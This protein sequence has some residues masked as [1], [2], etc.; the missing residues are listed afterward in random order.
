[1][2][3]L[4]VTPDSFSDGNRYASP[5]VAIEH[6]RRM[7]E[8]GATIIDVGGES[9]RPGAEPVDAEEE[10]RRVLPVIEG[11]QAGMDASDAHQAGL[12]S[13]DTCKASVAEAALGAGAHI[14][15][16]VS[17]LTG[18]DRMAEV[19]RAAGAGLVLMHMRGE[20]RTM[21]DDPRYDDVVREVKSY[22]DTRVHAAQSAG[23]ASECLAIDPGIG[24]GKTVEHNLQLLQGLGTFIAIGLPV[25]VGLSRKRFLGKITGRETDG[26][27]AAGVAANVYS[28][29]HGAAV[30][31][32]HD[33]AETMD[34]MEMTAA[35]CAEIS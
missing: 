19:V 4:N 11:L 17:A 34:A 32:V 6:G 1:M 15:N 16:D 10:S 14:V 33:V 8:E 3:V 13:I 21:Q 26:R 23:I 27:L 31:R 30:L 12:I 24:F 28:A 7:W 25:V 5:D 29:W 9:T 20:P 22:L 35:L 2:G 18:D